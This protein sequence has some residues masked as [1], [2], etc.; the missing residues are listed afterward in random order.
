MSTS[1]S[2]Y[3][4]D[5]SVLVPFLKQD[6]VISQ[7]L[8]KLTNFYVSSIAPGELYHGAVR[9]A[10]VERNRTDV[11]KLAST[12]IILVIDGTAAK[13][14]GILK[15]IQEMK[16]LMLPDNDLWIAATAFQFGLTLVTR[17]RH[18]NWIDG[19]AIEQ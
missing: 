4:V 7:R 5:S 12:A 11:D 1:S 14:Y 10:Y 15:R 2:S 18:F 8:A 13:R 16:G 6:A 17:D 3:L 9:S 19:L